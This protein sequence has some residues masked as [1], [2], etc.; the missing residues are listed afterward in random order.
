MNQQ[1]S[2]NLGSPIDERVA[3]RQSSM[4]YEELEVSQPRLGENQ[5]VFNDLASPL[6]EDYRD[7][8]LP[9][10]YLATLRA[11]SPPRSNNSRLGPPRP[12][13]KILCITNLD[14][15]QPDAR[16]KDVLTNEF[17]NFGQISISMCH[18][19]NERLVYIY[20]RT[21][22]EAR[23]ARHA[24][25]RAPI[26]DRPMEIEPI[27]EPS[28]P[29][30][31]TSPP[32]PAHPQN[33]YVRPGRSKRSISPPSAYYGSNEMMLRPDARS[34]EFHED[35]PRSQLM[36]G[37]H[38]SQ[39]G[40]SIGQPDAAHRELSPPPYHVDRAYGPPGFEAMAPY[41]PYEPRY[42]NQPAYGPSRT[43]PPEAYRGPHHHPS[44]FMAR[45]HSP[46]YEHGPPP[47][48]YQHPAP[49]PSH[50]YSGDPSV[51]IA[52]HPY[53]ERDRAHMEYPYRHP[54]GQYPPANLL[55]PPPPAPHSVNHR[56]SN[57]P[58]A[59]QEP[60]YESQSPYRNQS[61]PY[62][63]SSHHGPMNSQAPQSYRQRSSS[64]P[65]PTPPP[66]G[67]QP[68]QASSSS[69]SNAG[70]RAIEHPNR[71]MSREFRREKYGSEHYNIE[72]E[73][74]RPSRVIFVTN[75]S[76]QKSEDEL[77]NI[78]GQFGSIDELETRKISSEISSVLIKYSSMDCAYKAKTAINGK[79][80]GNI[81]CRITYGKVSA[82][83]RLWVGG[84]GSKTTESCLEDEF[85]K[86]GKIVNLEYTAGR[87]Y[88]FIEFE[89]A[90]QAQFATHHLKGTLS[91]QAERRLRIEYVDPVA[92]RDSNDN[93]DNSHSQSQD[94]RVSPDRKM[95]TPQGHTDAWPQ[96]Q[97]SHASPPM[98]YNSIDSGNFKRSP[99]PTEDI[100]SPA[101]KRPNL[102]QPRETHTF[103]SPARYDR[104]SNRYQPPVGGRDYYG[105]RSNDVKA[106]S[107][108]LNNNMSTNSNTP[109]RINDAERR[110]RHLT[111]NEK[112]HNCRS[113]KE[114]TDACSTSWVGRF[115]LNKYVFPSK[116]YLC[117]ED[118][119]TIEEYLTRLD[120]KNRSSVL[121]ITARLRL[122]TSK[123]EDI[124]RR[125]QTSNL[126][127]IIITS[128]PEDTKFEQTRHGSSPTN[129]KV[130]G[131]SKSHAESDD[132][133][134]KPPDETRVETSASSEQGALTQTYM[135][136]SLQILINYLEKKDAAGVI[137]LTG[138]DSELSCVGE[139]NGSAKH[140]N[141]DKSGK[142]LYAF[143]PSDMAMNLLK[144]S[145]P[146]LTENALKEEFL[147]GV[148]WSESMIPKSPR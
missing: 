142:L 101:N 43:M 129:D 58:M 90:N 139:D 78:F 48:T 49:Y 122:S 94:R 28:S 34:Y 71:Y 137:P 56:S 59:Y 102:E 127:F 37:Q 32:P 136:R 77:R 29:N 8:K 5:R 82:S 42:S 108:E 97:T 46:P 27:Y 135:S 104:A 15:H 18:D 69:S 89:S 50:P 112:L 40:P 66:N 106:N 141:L 128:C 114:V 63:P 19:G 98:Q 70:Q 39:H 120:A 21:Y 79:Y 80:L 33:P 44:R 86:F 126:G 12:T 116:M 41:S 100:S 23:S 125:M 52:A 68:A 103:E 62:S 117:S 123:L 146:N 132:A 144:S 20:F 36:Q 1:P 26:F 96:K 131:E 140:Q 87:P 84:F 7:N 75:V 25:S 4:N 31:A 61:A 30:M 130:N 57:Y 147:L 74:G 35:Y 60:Y 91:A 121:N 133:S 10:T 67:P 145:M 73:G 118:K 6:S 143:P 17:A 81:K 119:T 47:M 55:P 54:V 134:A 45:Q 88:A 95:D 9:S 64:R 107:R 113:I 65:R 24:K 138:S 16:I 99:S 13:Y 11:Q 14:P 110:E 51:P 83:P 2:S 124:K 85:G 105:S 22:E 76:E 92:T 148:I 93:N 3:A 72:P 53:R 115:A 38:Y 109:A 111:L